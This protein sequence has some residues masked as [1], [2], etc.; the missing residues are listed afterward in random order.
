MEAIK[1][2]KRPENVSEVQAFLGKINYYRAFVRNLAEVA[3]PLYQLLKKDHVF[4]WT[5]NCERAFERLKADIIN[6]SKL[7][8]YNPHKQ[9]ILA[10]DASQNGVGSVL[11]QSTKALKL[12]LNMLLKC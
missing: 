11:R 9:L 3:N 7:C 6:A 1:Q 12:H 2:L 5:T 4:N 10:T 8:H